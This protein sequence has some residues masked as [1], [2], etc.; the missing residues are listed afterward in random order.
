MEL[1]CCHKCNIPQWQLHSIGLWMFI[2]HRKISNGIFM[3]IFICWLSLKLLCAFLCSEYSIGR[4]L[5]VD[6]FYL[7]IEWIIRMNKNRFMLFALSL[8]FVLVCPKLVQNYVERV[9]DDIIFHHRQQISFQ[10]I[11]IHW[12]NWKKNSFIFSIFEMSSVNIKGRLYS[13]SYLLSHKI[14]PVE[15]QQI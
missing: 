12:P 5:E 6:I 13:K 7:C 9:S 1:F 2:R 3:Q 11:G 10:M 15:K 8:L 4:S 14:E